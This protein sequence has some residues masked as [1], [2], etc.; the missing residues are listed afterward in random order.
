MTS[1]VSFCFRHGVGVRDLSICS[2]LRAF[3]VIY[4]FL[5]VSFGL[6]GVLVFWSLYSWVLFICSASCVLYSVGSG[7]KRVHA[8]LGMRLFVCVHANSSCMY[9]L[10]FTFAMLLLMCIDVMVMSSEYVVNFTAAC[11]VGMS[12]MYMLNNVGDKTPSCRK[13][14]LN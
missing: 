13:P 4:T 10:M 9:D 1:V 14:V 2:V 3:V 11:G 5:Y 6:G 12:D 7:V 8:V